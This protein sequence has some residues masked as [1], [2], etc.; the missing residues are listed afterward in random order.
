MIKNKHQNLPYRYGVGLMILN[1]QNKIFMGKRIDS[2]HDSKHAWQMPQG[3]INLGET[4][5]SAAF[6]EMEE[7]IG[8]N[9]GDIIAESKS[10]YRYDIPEHLVEKLWSGQYKGQ[11][12]KWFLIKFNGTNEN[13]NLKKTKH[14]EF[15]RWQWFEKYKLSHVVVPFKKKL[16]KEVI[17]E[18][19]NLI[20]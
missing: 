14:P 7:E 6:R 5:S 3:G 9:N 12:L 2:H 4:P 17:I 10:W 18:F 15:Y 8:C 20:K 16:Y 19:K 13:I 11:Q 1:D